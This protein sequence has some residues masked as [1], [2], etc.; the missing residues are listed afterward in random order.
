MNAV[1]QMDIM[2][3]DSMVSKY[4]RLER[5]NEVSS[6]KLRKTI[7]E[8]KMKK[9]KGEIEELAYVINF[10]LEIEENK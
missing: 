4:K 9:L 7:T 1:I 2:R 3:L 5:L 10:S 8:P 6:N